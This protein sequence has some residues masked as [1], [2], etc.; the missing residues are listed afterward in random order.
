MADRQYVV[1]LKKKEDL[2][3]F[4]ADMKSDGF[5]LALKR[6]ISRNTHYFMTEEQAVEVAKDDRVLACE[7]TMEEQGIKP[8]PFG[9]INNAPHGYAG[10]FRKS[11]AFTDHNDRDWGKLSVSGTEAQ[12]RKNTWGEGAPTAV[13]ND[14]VEWFNNG[15]HVDVV[16]CDQPVSRDMEEWRSPSTNLSRFV[17]YEW[18]NELNGYVASIDDDGITLPTGNYPN[19]VDNINNLSSHGTHVAGTVAGKWYGWAVEANIYSMG[20]LGGAG[21][22]TVSTSTM[23]C[24]DYL[25]AFHRYKPINPETGFRNP[26]VTNHSWG[27]MLD[28]RDYGFDLPLD[29]SDIEMVYWNGNTYDQSNP[30]PSGWSM[31]G[32]DADFG[33]GEYSYTLPVHNTSMAADV[34]DAIQEGVVVISAAGNSDCYNP[35]SDQDPLWNNWVKFTGLNYY[36]YGYRGSSPGSLTGTDQIIN[37]GNMSNY[38]D[39]R[40]STSSNYGPG[41]K[42]WAPGSQILS[43]YNNAGY[44]DNK[45]GGSNYFRAISGTSMASPQVCGIAACLATNKDRFT[46]RDVIGFLEYASVNDFMTFDHGSQY[47]YYFIDFDAQGSG[48]YD[49]SGDDLYGTINGQNATINVNA[50]D[51]LYLQ[52]PVKN[53]FFYIISL[54]GSAWNGHY[55]DRDT[56]TQYGVPAP[57]MQA[58][59]GDIVQVQVAYTTGSGQEPI[60]IKTARTTGTGDQVSSGVTGQGAANTNDIVVWDTAG[61]S[62]GTYYYCSSNSSGCSGE[63]SLVAKGTYYNHPLYIKT[64]TGA[65]TSNQWTENADDPNGIVPNQGETH[66]QTGGY[67]L[68]ITFRVPYTSAGQTIYYQCGAHAGM[69]GQIVIHSPQGDINRPGN[70]AD[71]TRQ[72][73]SPNRMLTST[74]PRDLAPYIAAWNGTNKGRR[75]ATDEHINELNS[76]QNFPRTNT[77]FRP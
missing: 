8:V 59:V 71:N 19:Y 3:G 55:Y 16:I 53:S 47:Q 38:D 40:K 48:Y 12:R 2:E 49:V 24:F 39:Y 51:R 73:G 77:Y 1:T 45:Y 74:N 21:G 30:N 27:S 9:I 54:S 72:F 14:N 4:Y 67:N 66:G 63:I 10:D 64:Q 22:S 61:A 58:E 57:D 36:W 15:K 5:S 23:L 69:N 44:L 29:P 42:V 32:L 56:T 75:F 76:V 26:T 17:E 31:A 18:Y 60:Y 33:V 46:N 43:C 50:G 34:E 70:F 37:V 62:P 41:I 28:L 68:Y 35:E 20:I 52:Q 13:V 65:G 7:L 25:R 11:G 6:P